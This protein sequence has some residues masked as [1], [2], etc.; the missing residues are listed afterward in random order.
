MEFTSLFN[1]FKCENLYGRYI[2][3]SHIEPLLLHLSNNFIVEQI[4]HSVKQL[5]IHAVTF[6]HGKTKILMWSQMHG[7]ESTTTKA[8]FDLF[9]FLQSTNPLALHIK[10]VCTLKI[11]P[12][13]NPDGAKAYTRVNANE[14]DLNRDSVDL[15]QPES[16]LLRSIIEEFAPDFCLNLHD[17]RTIF[18]TTGHKLPA[19]VS[20]LSPSYN[21]SRAI[22]PVREKAMQLIVSMNQVLQNFIPNQVGRF[23]DGFNINCIGDMCTSLNIPTIL[24]EAGHYPNDYQR[25]ETRKYIFISYLAFFNALLT[26]AYLTN[27]I[28]DYLAIPE[29]TKSFFDILYKNFE[30][31]VGNLK[32]SFKF[33]VQYQEVLIENDIKFEAK[34]SQINN[35]DDYYGHLEYD[36]SEIKTT[37]FDANSFKVSQ[38]A[39]FKLNDN[40][41]IVN[42]LLIK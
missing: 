25:E 16:K 14:I 34:I 13:L 36:L 24:F 41:K 40:C 27:K 33:A 6:G 20:F 8:L 9:N 19:T 15:S 29:N 23:D 17:Q 28:E 21:E 32:K 26:N 42:G 22:N 4:G 12:I 1:Q 10:E 2:T 3:N 5:P 11:I 31:N 37:G 39:T 7:N 38:Q 35:L 30:F 18:G